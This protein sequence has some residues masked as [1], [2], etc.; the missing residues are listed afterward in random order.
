MFRIVLDLKQARQN[1]IRLE[2]EAH[3]YFAMSVLSLNNPC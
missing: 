3:I 1:Y 2:I